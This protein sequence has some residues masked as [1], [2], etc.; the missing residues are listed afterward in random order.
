M[1]YEE[2]KALIIQSIIQAK[3]LE[4]IGKNPTIYIHN[5]PLKEIDQLV[6]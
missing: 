5:D 6:N 3:K 1:I 4:V 2:K